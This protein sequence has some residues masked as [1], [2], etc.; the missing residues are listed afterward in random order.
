[1]QKEMHFELEGH[2]ETERLVK[3]F[4]QKSQRRSTAPSLPECF[5]KEEERQKEGEKKGRK[6]ASQSGPD[7]HQPDS[8]K[9]DVLLDLKKLDKTYVIDLNDPGIS[10][11]FLRGPSLRPARKQALFKKS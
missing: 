6:E 11:E 4:G 7:E 9:K 5:Q 2:L 3:V 8:K 1:M 10:L